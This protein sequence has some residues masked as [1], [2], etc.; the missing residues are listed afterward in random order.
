M[1]N[2]KTKTAN[3]SVQHY[4]YSDGNRLEEVRRDTVAG[5]L[6]YSFDY[7]ANGSMIGKFNG[8]GQPI[9]NVD[10]DQR[11]LATVM[12]VNN[13]DNSMA[14]EYDANAYRI[15]KQ[16]SAGTKK[17]MLEAEHMESIYDDQDELQATYLRGVVVDEI[18]NGFEKNSSGVMENR[19]FHH[20]QVNSVVAL[21]DHNG[22]TTQVNSYGPYG[23]VF[24]STGSSHNT[25]QYTGREQD[26]QSG[27]YYYR[28]RYY[29]P[30]LGRFISEDPAGFEGG[31]NFYV[32]VG[33]NPLIYADPTGKWVWH[34]VGAGLGAGLNFA[35]QM[36]ANG[37]DYTKVNYYTVA[38]CGVAGAMG[39]GLGAAISNLA[40]GARI[41]QLGA[42]AVYSANVAGNAAVG[43]ALNSGVQMV[44][45]VSEGKRNWD[46]VDDTGSAFGYGMAAG[47]L[48]TVIPSVTSASLTRVNV[49][50][51]KGGVS[52][53][54]TRLATGLGNAVGN[55]TDAISW[56]GDK[57]FGG[58]NGESDSVSSGSV[59]SS[60]DW[61]SGGT[62][63]DF[64]GYASDMYNSSVRSVYAK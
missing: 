40:N 42:S 45:N 46:I 41:A 31:I 50:G 28:A 32:Y 8:A 43:G 36:I 7:D 57:M 37:G 52:P 54:G 15:Q 39:V 23:E 4:I 53:G 30:E 24:G 16:D 22:N 55:A 18:I 5:P 33:N 9:L 62:T 48:G 34:V 47:T 38:A 27:L 44:T 63:A 56:A 64:G 59:G 17:Y 3:G 6:V 25:M 13:Q 35:S 60:G 10:Y 20:D 51:G 2:R 11:R 58:S 49:F 21:S 29:D 19:T 14:F 26:A 61:V 12:G 1:G